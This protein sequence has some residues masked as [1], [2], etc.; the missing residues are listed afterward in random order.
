LVPKSQ[1]T[2]MRGVFLVAAKLAKLG[3]IV[4]PTARN[5]VGADLLVT[6]G[7]CTRAMTVQVKANAKRARDW[8]VGKNY[9][10]MVSD[11]HIYVLVNGCDD[12]DVDYYVVPSDVIETKTETFERLNSTW[13]AVKRAAI[14]TYRAVADEDWNRAFGKA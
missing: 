11:T 2:G 6:D 3:F 10:S 5:A 1:I 12:E 8:Q 4:S 9:N 7:N 13:Y 14:E